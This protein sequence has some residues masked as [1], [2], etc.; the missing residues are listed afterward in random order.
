MNSAEELHCYLP[1]N[2]LRNCP[3]GDNAC[4]HMKRECRSQQLPQNP[5][6]KTIKLQQQVSAQPNESSQK[7]AQTLFLGVQPLL[8]ASF[9]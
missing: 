7:K 6:P 5:N 9:Q 1:N 4:L 2:P 3:N 8:L